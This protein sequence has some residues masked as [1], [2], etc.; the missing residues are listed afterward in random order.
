V[1]WQSLFGGEP[2][3]EIEL[4]EDH[5]DPS[6]DP[7][8]RGLPAIEADPVHHHLAGRR[9]HQAVQAPQQGGLAGTRAAE[10]RHELPGPDAEVDVDQS[11]GS[12]RVGLPEAGDL[13]HA[14]NPPE[15]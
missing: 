13:D 9:R 5:P 6:T 11:P 15:R 1:T 10:K 12:A 7:P 2:L 3:D 8:Q 4:L 14:A